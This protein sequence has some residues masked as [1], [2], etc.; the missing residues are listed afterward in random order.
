MAWRFIDKDG[1]EAIKFEHGKWD[2]VMGYWCKLCSC[3][4]LQ[5]VHAERHENSHM[6]NG[7][8]G[9]CS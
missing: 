2:S 7:E 3:F 1:D 4:V 6:D 5:P 8:W 9:T